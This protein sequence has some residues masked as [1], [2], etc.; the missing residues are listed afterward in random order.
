MTKKIELLDFSFGIGSF[1]FLFSFIFGFLKD[2][3]KALGSY[4]GVTSK[5]ALLT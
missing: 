5:P 1:I 3:V 4:W 2:T